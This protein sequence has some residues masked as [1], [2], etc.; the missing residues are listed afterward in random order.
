VESIILIFPFFVLRLLS[1]GKFFNRGTQVNIEKTIKYRLIGL[2]EK[3]RKAEPLD[4]V[5][6]SLLYFGDFALQN[7]LKIEEEKPCDQKN[8][9][10]IL[11][12]ELCR[13][14]INYLIHEVNKDLCNPIARQPP[15]LI[16]SQ[17]DSKS[18]FQTSKVRILP[19]I[20]F[21]LSYLA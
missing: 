19:Q 18:R 4:Y 7:L 11:L 20:L 2:T 10:G 12:G 17:F 13:I 6:T 8:N 3:C 16:P 5:V 15:N 1:N 21:S 9:K 14:G